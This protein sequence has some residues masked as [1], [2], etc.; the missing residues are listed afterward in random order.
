MKYAQQTVD[1][2]VNDNNLKISAEL[3]MLDLTSELGELAKEILKQTAYGKMPL[4]VDENVEGEL[5]DCIFSLL[6]LCSSLGLDA[7]E[8]LNKALIKYKKRLCEKGVID[9]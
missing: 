1:R 9:S 2:F 7:E 6:C 4:V 3:R 8:A 5:G